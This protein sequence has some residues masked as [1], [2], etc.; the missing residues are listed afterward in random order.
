MPL[1]GPF[2]AGGVAALQSLRLA[3]ETINAEGGISGRRV[4]LVVADSQGRAESARTEALRLVERE[5]VWALIGAYLSEETLP[6]QDVAADKQVLHMVP[7]AAAME[8]SERV[9]QDPRFRFSFRVSY[10]VVQW[11]SLLGTFLERMGSRQYAFVG[12]NIR[13]NRELLDHLKSSLAGKAEVVYEGFYSPQAPQLEPLV[14]AVR[15]RRPD[16]VVLGDPGVGAIEFVKRARELDL[17]SRLLS[18]GGALGDARVAAALP[19]GEYL[20]FQAAAWRGLTPQATQYFSRFQKQYRYLPVGYSDTLPHDALTVLA[21]AAVR[22]RSF[23]PA[24]VIRVLEQGQFAG[25]AGIYTFDRSDQALWG[26]GGL[27]GAVIQWVN[28]SDR[29]ILSR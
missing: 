8:V 23:A 25:V 13:W 17:P 7:V 14:V 2:A 1:S 6:V 26:Q 20:Y 9:A 24:D 18:V 29:V 28:G 10:N 3:E 21:Q 5:G 11:A 27:K 12:V 15:E 22:A 4:V 19:S 16:F